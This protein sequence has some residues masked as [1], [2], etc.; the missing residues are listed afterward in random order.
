M[1]YLK[2]S[3]SALIQDVPRRMVGFRR[4]ISEHAIRLLLLGSPFHMSRRVT[5][6]N[7]TE[8]EHNIEKQTFDSRVVHPYT[9]GFS[10]QE[11][12]EIYGYEFQPF[13]KN[14]LCYLCICF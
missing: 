7:A 14:T 2:L 12:T 13:F 4:L 5:V 1:K 6:G 10:S 9:F 11:L 3:N 8:K